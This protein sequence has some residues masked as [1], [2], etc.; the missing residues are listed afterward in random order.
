MDQSAL[1][2]RQWIQQTGSAA[3]ALTAAH[4]G[5]AQAADRNQL[6]LV[7][8]SDTHVGYKDGDSAGKRWQSTAAEIAQLDTE[9]VLHLGDVIDGGRVEQYPVYLEAREQITKPVHEV[10]GNH[11]P[12][13]AFAKYLRT[14]IDTVI[15]H[16]WLRCILIGNAHRDSHD[17]YFTNEQL[18][19]LEQQLNNAASDD[20][21]A[22]ICCHVPV[23]SNRHPDRGWFVKPAHGQ[24]RFYEITSKHRESVLAVMHGHFH[25]GIRGWTNDNGLHEICL[26][27]ALYNQDRGL[28]VKKAPGFYT[29]EFRPGYTQLQVGQGKLSLQYKPTGAEPTM[30]RTLPTS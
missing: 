15:D 23:H 25:N 2:R 3:L 21:L 1:N 10:P 27:S 12:A 28:E 6:S 19:W 9:L 20:R 14:E 16:E 26:P 11:D 18:D 5:I 24:T 30:T 29:S 8:I 22:L 13:D 17:G 4:V 7:V